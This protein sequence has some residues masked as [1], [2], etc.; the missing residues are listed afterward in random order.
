MCLCPC[1]F[2]ALAAFGKMLPQ[3]GDDQPRFGRDA[4][5][6]LLGLQPAHRPEPPYPFPDLLLGLAPKRPDP[7][8]E[9]GWAQ[10]ILGAC[11][12]EVAN[13]ANRIPLLPSVHSHVAQPYY[14]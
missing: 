5:P 14:V 7:R 4:G 2:S 12:N 8:C 1:G 11:E 6:A 9:V 10:P 13:R 3:A